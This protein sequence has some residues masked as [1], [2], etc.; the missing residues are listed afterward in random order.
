VGRQRLLGLFKTVRRGLHLRE[1]SDLTDGGGSI[2]DL[3]NLSY[4]AVGD[5][6]SAR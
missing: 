5:S 3:G 1:A 6:W 2:D 4:W